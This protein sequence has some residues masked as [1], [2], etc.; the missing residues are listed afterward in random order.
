M[1]A[2]K[3]CALFLAC[4]SLLCLTGCWG[5]EE[6][7]EVAYVLTIGF[8]KG[9][10]GDLTVTASIANPKVIAG[11]TG[12]GGGGAG[13]GAGAGGKSTL[14][15]SVETYA[16]LA[17]FDLFNAG[18]DRKISLEHTKA[19]IFSEELAREGLGKWVN[20]LVRYRE[21]RPTSHII[22]CRGK[23]KDI[24]EKNNPMLELSPTK[25]FE[26]VNKL[27]QSH[28]L[29][30]T[31]QFQDFYEDT[32]SLSIC[33][34]IP[35][36]ALHEGGLETAKPGPEK[37]GEIQLGKYTAGEVPIAG[38]NQ[39]QIMGSAVFRV[40]KMVGVLDG[41]E[42][43]YYMMLRGTFRNGTISIQDPLAD[44]PIPAGLLVHRTQNKYRT[45]IDQ[46]GNV[47][48]DVDIYLEPEIIGLFSG[49]NYESPDYK[50]ILEEAFSKYIEQGCRQLLRRSQE[51]FKADI[52]GFGY[53]VK[54]HFWTMQQWQAFDW[55]Q[56]YPEAQVNVTVHTKIRRTGLMLK[57]TPSVRGE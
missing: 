19:F 37:G 16:P 48:I 1:R 20:P 3:L 24:I 21:L 17:A 36:V 42:T 44:K 49:I 13:A 12:G 55:L 31:T 50:P 47:A 9:E 2:A 10:K 5:A 14:V 51:E 11:M 6:T 38:G 22:I 8:D 41:Q 18:I 30:Q 35:L 45:S 25:Q 57:T 23:A 46:N 54:H 26:L 53:Q 7:D 33:P 27:S 15:M 4:I 32:K 40:D 39:A 29:Y 34:N 52:F 28:G 56:R 43:R